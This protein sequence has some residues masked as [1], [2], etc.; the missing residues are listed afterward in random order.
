M[1]NVTVTILQNG[2]CDDYGI[3]LV[4]GSSYSLDY[5]K[6]KA[7]WQAGFAYV[8]DP[9]VFNRGN[10][11]PSILGTVKYLP[12]SGFRKSLL[13][14]LVANS[15][16]S[17]S[18]GLVTIAATSHGITTGAT[19][20]GF[21]FFY[22][23]STSLAAEWYDSVVSIPDANTITFFAPGDDFGSQSINSAAAYTTQVVV[24]GSVVL[25]AHSFS[26]SM[27]IRVSAS[28]GG[29]TTGA[30]KSW[31]PFVNGLAL[32]ALTGTSLPFTTREADLISSLPG[33]IGMI[34]V[35]GSGSSMT[36]VAVNPTTELTITNALTISAAADFA[37]ILV[38]PAVLLFER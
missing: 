17:R 10:S 37:A 5:D 30:T 18:N 2:R 35:G 12:F 4:A 11:S 1:A 16:A 9:T 3:P 13:A 36:S 21:R 33:Q 23:G 28:C 14:S 25:P 7:L 22:P 24:P 27:R 20:Q 32:A 29:G 26:D 38:P 8:A 6:A 19:Y 34:V 15:T 31:R